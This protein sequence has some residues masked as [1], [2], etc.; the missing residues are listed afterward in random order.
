M[1]ITNR[2]YRL[3]SVNG[4][5][6]LE[7]RYIMSQVLKRPLERSEHIHHLNGD[8]L[9]NRLENLELIAADEHGRMHGGESK[10]GGLFNLSLPY[11]W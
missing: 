5:L 10:G 2:G 3:I 6:V 7:H 1:W 9:D 8:K 4:K 11:L